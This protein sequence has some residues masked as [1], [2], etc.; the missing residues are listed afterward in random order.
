MTMQE[1]AK[2]AGVHKSTVDKVVHNRP[3]VSDEV[4]Q[5][6]K[7][8]LEETNYQPNRAAQALQYQKRELKIGIVLVRV[9]ALVFLQGGILNGLKEYKEY[10]IKTNFAAFSMAESQKMAEKLHEMAEQHYD[11]V[12]LSPINAQC[13]RE[14][15]QE[16]ADK[17]IPVVTVN[18]DL[19]GI[20]RLCY[21]GQDGIKASQTAGRLMAECLGETS[22]IA[23]VTSAV[24]E[25]NSSYYVKIRETYFI[26]YMQEHYPETEIVEV[27]E[28][29]ENAEITQQKTQELLEKEPDLDGIYITCGGVADVAEAV[30]DAGRAGKIKIIGYESYPQIVKLMEQGCITFSIDSDIPGQGKLAV[31]S[32]MQY[33]LDKKKPKRPEVHTNSRILVQELL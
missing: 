19:D 30:R 13:V 23:V 33:L 1:I 4:R 25:E 32:I 5:R 16:L 7:K 28:S 21:V 29:M 11:G 22:K 3:G 31:R 8:L 20:S 6:I 18:S 24:A 17:N 26:R 2:M 14:A 10:N 27:I 15:L 12:I 9:D